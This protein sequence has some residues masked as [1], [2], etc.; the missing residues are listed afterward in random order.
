M[1]CLSI[2]SSRRIESEYATLYPKLLHDPEKFQN[3][4]PMSQQ[5]FQ[6]LHD[7]IKHDI[8]PGLTTYTD[9]ISIE[10]RLFVIEK[11]KYH[12]LNIGGRKFNNIRYADDTVLLTENAEDLQLLAEAVNKHSND[13]DTWTVPQS[14]LK[15][16]E[17]FE[18]WIYRR[19]AKISWKD[20]KTN[21]ELWE[22]LGTRRE[23]VNTI[24]TRKIKYFGHTKRHASFLK[25][26]LEGKIEGSRPRGETEKTVDRRHYKME[27]ER[28][29]PMHCGGPGQSKV[30][31]RF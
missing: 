26:V 14:K 23:L 5:S 12:G 2:Y 29:T 13:A 7:L 8:Q 24:K 4:A 16:I 30:E 9:S 11:S 10:E 17:A 28:Y 15:K 1:C 27:R 6:E 3:F 18:M 22:H 19:L 20:K 21:Q 31:I 25:D